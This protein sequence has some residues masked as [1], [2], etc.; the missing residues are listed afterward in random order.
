MTMEKALIDEI[1]WYINDYLSSYP[2]EEDSEAF[3]N[4]S[5][6][7]MKKIAEILLEQDYL[8]ETMNGMIYDA[9]VNHP[10]MWKEQ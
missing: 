7:E 2:D 4:I 10:E 8:W 5:P 3:K 9:I 6:E 1:K